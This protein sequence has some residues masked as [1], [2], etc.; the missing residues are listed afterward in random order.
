MRVWEPSY[1]A[2]THP[3]VTRLISE[4][5][6]FAGAERSDCEAPPAFNYMISTADFSS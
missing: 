4:C 5:S 2:Q 3:R 6:R 1:G